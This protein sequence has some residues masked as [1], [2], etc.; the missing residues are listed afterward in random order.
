MDI[1]SPTI[2]K[3][4]TAQTRKGDEALLP[5]T[6]NFITDSI[7]E[8]YREDFFKCIATLRNRLER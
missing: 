8:N 4:T 6:D 7:L 5:V 2:G 3:K 1:I